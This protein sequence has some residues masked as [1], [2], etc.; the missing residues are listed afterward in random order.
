MELSPS[1]CGVRD[2]GEW[3][4]GPL[5]P[6]RDTSLLSLPVS[7]DRVQ[8]AGEPPALAGGDELYH[9]TRINAP[10]EGSFDYDSMELQAHQDAVL[11]LTIRPLLL[12]RS[13]PCLHS[14]S[15]RA[16]PMRIWPSSS[17]I[18]SPR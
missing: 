2:V 15:R 1:F 17:P 5:A 16:H 10:A 12:R 6:Y 4:R 11:K 9:E 7:A 3:V 13:P 14:R 18:R 8:P